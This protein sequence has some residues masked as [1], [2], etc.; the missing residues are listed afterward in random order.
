MGLVVVKGV[1]PRAAVFSSYGSA[2]K[3]P[4][5]GGEVSTYKTR[6]DLVLSL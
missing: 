2:Q 4:T 6:R 3:N 5:Q 1:K